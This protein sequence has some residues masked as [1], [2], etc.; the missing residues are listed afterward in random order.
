MTKDNTC[1]SWVKRNPIIYPTLTTIVFALIMIYAIQ[2]YAEY[3]ETLDNKKNEI[4]S[5]TQNCHEIH[6]IVNHLNW[7]AKSIFLLRDKIKQ[8][9]GC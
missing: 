6:Y 4:L 3:Y 1:L 8:E 5:K 7:D 9:S 2:Y